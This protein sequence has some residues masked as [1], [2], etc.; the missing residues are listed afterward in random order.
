MPRYTGDKS[1]LSKTKSNTYAGVAFWE[2]GSFL[3]GAKVLLPVS[4]INPALLA[5]YTGA[6]APGTLYAMSSLYYFL[7]TP[8]DDADET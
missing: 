2:F 3:A 8:A 7:L 5:S 1:R 6:I 4:K